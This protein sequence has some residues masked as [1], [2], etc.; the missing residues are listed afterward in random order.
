MVEW[1]LVVD[2]TTH[3]KKEDNKGQVVHKII[4]EMSETI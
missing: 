4:S 1:F 3:F 2:Y